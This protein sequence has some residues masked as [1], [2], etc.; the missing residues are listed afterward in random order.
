MNFAGETVLNAMMAGRG[1]GADELALGM[2]KGKQIGWHYPG[3]YGGAGLPS[4]QNLGI[5]IVIRWW[6]SSAVAK[7]AEDIGGGVAR[8][9]K[10]GRLEVENPF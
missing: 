9:K 3:G 4:G 5:P 10:M 6:C 1:P 8:R 2:M 7:L